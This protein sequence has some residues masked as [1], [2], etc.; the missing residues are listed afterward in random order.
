MVNLK[1]RMDHVVLEDV[2]KTILE[3]VEKSHRED[4]K[5][6]AL[7]VRANSHIFCPWM[8]NTFS[9]ML[10]LI[11]HGNIDSDIEFLETTLSMVISENMR[12]D[13]CGFELDLE[14]QANLIGI[15][16]FW[17]QKE[18]NELWISKSIVSITVMVWIALS[19]GFT[20][21]YINL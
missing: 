7:L 5:K 6:V 4:V 1:I 16:K 20:D 13:A 14:K 9:S 3:N 15:Q 12:H 11:R 2:Y 21:G 10:A 18:S 19:L 17:L 8:E